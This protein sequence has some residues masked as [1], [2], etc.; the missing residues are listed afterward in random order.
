MTLACDIVTL[1]LSLLTRAM[2]TGA[3]AGD[4]RLTGKAAVTPSPRAPLAGRLMVPGL[5]FV[6]TVTLVVALAMPGVNEI[7]VIVDVPS[8]TAV[9]RTL[10]VVEFAAKLTLAGTVTT[11]VLLDVRFTVRPLG[12]AAAERFRATLCEVIPVIET[13]G[14]AKL[15]TVATCT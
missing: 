8:P 1:L 4:D 3:V 2:V 13:V 14:E 10:T 15:I 12:G 9:N 11:P 5:E 6:E 7:A